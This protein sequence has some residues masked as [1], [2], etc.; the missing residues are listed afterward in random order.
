MDLLTRAEITREIAAGLPAPEEST[1]TSILEY[2][3][4]HMMRGQVA[5]EMLD[6]TE[7]DG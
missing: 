1:E 4:R 2:L 3:N 5:G 7:K 6:L